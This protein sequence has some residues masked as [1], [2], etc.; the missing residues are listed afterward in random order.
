MDEVTDCS[1]KNTYLSIL[2]IRRDYIRLL[3]L[4]LLFWF[5]FKH[6]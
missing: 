4:D 2:A 3:D 5:V 1:V 6:N